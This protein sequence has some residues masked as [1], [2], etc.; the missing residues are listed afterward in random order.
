MWKVKSARFFGC[1]T[2]LIRDD[3][4]TCMKIV[5]TFFLSIYLWHGVPAS[6]AA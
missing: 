4:A 6:W 1:A 2:I 3:G 5:F